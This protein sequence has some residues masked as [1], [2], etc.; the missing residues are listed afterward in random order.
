MPIGRPDPRTPNGRM[1]KIWIV[2]VREYSAAVRTK[3]FMIG[4]LMMPLMMGGSL[5]VQHLLK[6]FR[7]TSDKHFAVIDRSPDGRFFAAIQEAVKNHNAA[8]ATKAQGLPNLV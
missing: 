8:P 7:D 5:I 3:A 6:G 4:L 1:R 2:A